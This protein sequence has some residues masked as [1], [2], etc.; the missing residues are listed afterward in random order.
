[1]R[2]VFTKREN[3]PERLEVEA[4]LVFNHDGTYLD[5]LKLAGFSIWKGLEGDLYVTLPARGFGMGGDRRYFDFL[6]NEETG[7]EATKRLKAWIIE[8]YQ[9]WLVRPEEV[10]A[11]PERIEGYRRGQR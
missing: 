3:G 10:A 8:Q 4:E 1:M 5:G 6:R 7:S 11:A 9:A 2:V